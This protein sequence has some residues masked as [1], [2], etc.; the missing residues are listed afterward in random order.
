MPMHN[1]ESDAQLRAQKWEKRFKKPV[2]RQACVALFAWALLLAGGLGWLAWIQAAQEAAS[3]P[4]ADTL[5]SILLAAL[6][7]GV[8][9]LAL[10]AVQLARIGRARCDER[11]GLY[12]VCGVGS[13][14][15]CGGLLVAWAV[16][17]VA[18]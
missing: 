3:V 1:P 12:Y 15:L 10:C 11:P 17:R 5:R 16:C 7:P 2:I 8:P 4:L 9:L 6:L 18:G 14:V 13:L